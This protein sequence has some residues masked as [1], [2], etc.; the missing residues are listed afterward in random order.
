MSESASSG[1]IQERNNWGGAAAV[2]NANVKGKKRPGV[3]TLRL[4]LVVTGGWSVGESNSRRQIM[5]SLLCTPH[6]LL[7][8]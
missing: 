3:P 7:F 6:F 5:P 4:Q 2:E 8:T 1:S